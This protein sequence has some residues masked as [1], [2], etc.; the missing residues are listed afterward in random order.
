MHEGF[1][2]KS[3]LDQLDA[4]ADAE[5]TEAA[6]SDESSHGS[7]R[8]HKMNQYY[9]SA[10]PSF[11]TSFAAFPN[12]TRQPQRHQQPQPQPPYFQDPFA[13]QLASP[14][15]QPFDPRSS[16]D[17]KGYPPLQLDY[18]QQQRPMHSQTPYGPHVP[19]GPIGGIPPMGNMQ[20]DISTIFVVGFP[21]DM[22]EREFQNMFT[23]SPG[24]EAATL[25]IPNK[26]Y[27]A[28]SGVLSPQP[29]PSLPNSNAANATNQQQRPGLG[30]NDPYNL[31]NVNQGGVLVDVAGREGGIASWPA[32]PPP[33]G[34]SNAGSG[35][36]ATSQPQMQQPQ[37]F[38]PGGMSNL[39]GA[40]V[41]PML[42]PR[43]QIIG[44]AKFRTRE[45]ALG[46]RDVL[47]GR[48]VDI[49]KGAVLKAEMAK[50]NLHT[51]RG[52]GPVGGGVVGGGGANPNPNNINP[53]MN[54]INPNV[55]MNGAAMMN[56]GMMNEM[57]GG[58]EAL[59]PREREAGGVGRDGLARY[60]R[61]RRSALSLP[62]PQ[63]C[64]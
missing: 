45:E 53:G 44:F 38:A 20:E 26:E 16:F 22:Q 46:A 36:E 59:S 17:F 33:S 2:N 27:T 42:P 14:V 19:M 50:K 40:G 55:G 8:V 30:P 15:Q 3:L 63:P 52:V 23:F 51:K 4:Q 47:Q 10:R 21:E 56:G 60:A 37:P 1:L 6:T 24:F 43:K 34:A 64:Q 28:Y 62:Q 11:A 32:P 54:G 48:R 49:D 25:K 31:V 57:Y 9:P 18:Q 29:Q 39:A 12:S 41:T 13:P 5:P 61:W 58:V 7:P 35:D